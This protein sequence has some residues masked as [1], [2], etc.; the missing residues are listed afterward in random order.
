MTD[1]L[2]S[3]SKKIVKTMK[4]NWLFVQEN[5]VASAGSGWNEGYLPSNKF[6]YFSEGIATLPEKE[7]KKR[8]SLNN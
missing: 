5:E 6:L 2:T 1:L 8:L 7:L 3:D 4:N